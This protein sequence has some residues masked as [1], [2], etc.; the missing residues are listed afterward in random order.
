MLSSL[1]SKVHLP[2]V[3]LDSQGPG[4]TDGGSNGG[5]GHKSRLCYAT[6]E[7]TASKN[8]PLHF[9][10]NKLPKGDE[11]FL[12]SQSY[13]FDSIQRPETNTTFIMDKEDAI[14]ANSLPD[15]S[16]TASTEQPV[17]KGGQDNHAFEN[18][19]EKGT[20]SIS[21]SPPPHE[22]VNL[23]LVELTPP[24]KSAMD[25]KKKAG[26]P[27]DHFIAVNEHKKGLRGEKLY[28]TKD[29]RGSGGK[30]CR[31]KL[32]IALILAVLITA[33]V[34]AILVGVGVID[35]HPK[36]A[37]SNQENLDTPQNGPRVGGVI[38][39]DAG[40]NPDDIFG[41]DVEVP[42]S[43]PDSS[44]NAL[45][46]KLRLTSLS[47]DEDLKDK[48]S[49]AYQ[50]LVAKLES[51][52][53]QT[54]TGLDS[55]LNINIVG[56]EEGSVI[57][58]YRI[59]SSNGGS[60][61]INPEELTAKLMEQQ[62]VFS[63]VYKLDPRSI[64]LDYLENEC[65]TL[66]CSDACYYNYGANQF[67]CSCPEG[68]VL[69]TD[70]RTC[71]GNLL[72]A[73]DTILF[74]STFEADVT[75]TT[76]TT[77]TTPSPV[78]ETTFLEAEESIPE[79]TEEP[80]PEETDYPHPEET[81]DYLPEVTEREPSPEGTEEPLPEAGGE[82]LPEGTEEPLPE[83]GG[84]P[85]PE[86]TEE[87]IRESENYDTESYQDVSGEQAW[88]EIL[89]STD[90]STTVEPEVP[91]TER[92]N[93][94]SSME[95]DEDYLLEV[96]SF[97]EVEVIAPEPTT[98]ST[99]KEVEV[100]TMGSAEEVEVMPTLAPTS[101]DI[102]VPVFGDGKNI[103]V[104]IEKAVEHAITKVVADMTPF[105]EE[106]GHGTDYTTTKLPEV[107]A[108]DISES[109][110]GRHASVHVTAAPIEE[111]TTVV[112][113]LPVDTT[114]FHDARMLELERT[115]AA[116]VSN[117]TSFMETT[118]G[119]SSLEYDTFDIQAET[120]TN[121]LKEVGTK[122]TDL[123]LSTEMTHADMTTFQTLMHG[124][125]SDEATTTDGAILFEEVTS[126]Q[127]V[128]TTASVEAEAPS[129][130]VAGAPLGDVPEATTVIPLEEKPAVEA[131]ASTE[132][133]VEVPATSVPFVEGPTTMTPNVGV[134][135]T[136]S[137]AMEDAATT[138]VPNLPEFTDQV[139]VEI[140]TDV[141]FTTAPLTLTGVASDVLPIQSEEDNA[142]ETE[143][144]TA[145]TTTTQT[146][147]VSRNDAAVPR[148]L[149]FNETSED[150]ISEEQKKQH[151]ITDD[152]EE[153]SVLPEVEQLKETSEL[154]EVERVE[155]SSEMPVVEELEKTS[156]LPKMSA[157]G[158]SELPKVQG[159][160]SSELTEVEELEKTTELLKL[161]VEGTTELPKVQVEESSGL[162]EV[163]ELE[164]TT[165]LPKL[166]VEGTTELPKVQVEESSE[167]SEV[168]E[169]EKTSK[170]PEVEELE[171]TSELPKV[172]VEGT[173]ELP[174]VEAITE[175]AA[176]TEADLAKGLQIVDTCSDQFKCSDE[177]C[178]PRDQVCNRIRDCSDGSDETDCGVTICMDDEFKCS[179]SGR[180]IPWSM[181]CDGR[182]DCQDG[183]DELKCQQECSNGSFLCPE[184][185]CIS[186][187]L[188]CD[189][190]TDCANGEDEAECQCGEDEFSCSMG[191][192]CIMR[193]KV[194]D[195]TGDCPDQSDE[196]SCIQ[197]DSNQ[198]LQ[199]KDL[200]QTWSTVCSFGWDGILST[201]ACLQMGF[202]DVESTE[203]M[204]D[205]IG[206][207]LF[208]NSTFVFDGPLQG[209]LFEEEEKN[210][211]NCAKWKISATALTSLM[212]VG[213]A[214]N[215]A[216][217]PSVAYIFNV[218]SKSS[219]TG[220]IL[221]PK[222]VL[223]SYRCIAEK[224]LDPLHWVAFGGP[225]GPNEESTD[226][227]ST[228]TQ[229]KMVE[230]IIKHPGSRYS[231]GFQ[232]NDLALIQLVEPFNFTKSDKLVQGICL[233][234]SPI[235][236]GQMCVTAGWSDDEEGGSTFHQYV[237]YMPMP[238]YDV[239][240]CNST[241]HY[242]GLLSSD[243]F[244]T[245][246][247]PDASGCRCKEREVHD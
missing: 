140:T 6:V 69:G 128:T 27:D 13:D 231:Q 230:Q 232:S 18:S 224:E 53:K 117:V 182:S 65:Q 189:G 91:A 163:E 100:S 120:T 25:G 45:E 4:R 71:Q 213:Q 134:P 132:V 119:D 156:E 75:S 188:T 90:S 105:T 107:V 204:E 32:C 133:F 227:L 235:E 86:G 72:S 113:L 51:E 93:I 80:L 39:P 193:S 138:V 142:V 108:M 152:M 55:D 210:C 114:E 135:S 178:I 237:D 63:S 166:S 167:L 23:E 216:P 121:T 92:R 171:K 172:S 123:G 159:E 60:T 215:D 95:H 89:V 116:V 101:I 205:S 15:S 207:P 57:I 14:S 9:K 36:S 96:D 170:L 153:S 1:N 131:P 58:R 22:A 26:L 66:D 24:L 81:E 144:I 246:S 19:M 229:I 217:W 245:G 11:Y 87:P 78:L 206:Q 99:A 44:P 208:V 214:P 106:S 136:V 73:E 148:N 240:K 98:V 33:I 244:C 180:C 82:P 234:N 56:L 221:S 143:T 243:T 168:E 141:P 43:K 31:K 219:C 68:K 203:T 28:V 176:T 225:A 241:D 41:K 127:Q 59:G 220:S 239:D 155:D 76:T 74:G 169:L 209:A 151:K 2:T 112:S 70:K 247:K 94:L 146:P 129:T 197:T 97:P 37:D 62:S 202:E 8:G 162:P 198:V 228:G 124:S 150:R 83:A 104:E 47:W 21:P 177:S 149:E 174:E 161:S 34:V 242:N 84:E 199:V 46:G 12:V 7:D 190:T 79:G 50:E 16:S 184:G 102:M 20:P 77:S 3:L 122:M 200:N 154:P 233:S 173:S 115:L 85:L 183:E 164:K 64:Q 130:T 52:L 157:E 181:Q 109:L 145:T 223:T 54:L 192:G 111:A 165:E 38:D 222:W 212:E 88:P 17:P 158:T 30:S 35:P 201:G 195:G 196:W 5:Q 42:S 186:K 61:E 211:S 191:G 139:S 185:F 187:S 137:P 179:T 40:G 175:A 103:T 125:T 226:G 48:D 194:C 218:N 110:E 29:Q 67:E 126:P 238:N 236:G 10:L 160:E 118:T 147:S 49:K